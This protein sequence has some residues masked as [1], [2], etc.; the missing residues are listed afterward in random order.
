MF[1]A[2]APPKVSY[3]VTYNHLPDIYI[4]ILTLH[5]PD[6]LNDVTS[7]AISPSG[8]FVAAGSLDAIVRI[9][10]VATGVLVMRLRGH[11]D[12]V[13]CVAFTPDGRG[14][15]SGSLDN[16]LKLWENWKWGRC[17]MTFTGQEVVSRT[18]FLHEDLPS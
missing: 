4:Q 16:T 11:Q 12:S 5:D 8:R 10:E 9:W 14:I 3:L 1:N 6:W 17:L 13:T 7:V 15:V 18:S 2:E